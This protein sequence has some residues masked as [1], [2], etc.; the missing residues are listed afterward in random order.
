LGGAVAAFVGS[1]SVALGFTFSCFHTAW[2]SAV[3][4][5]GRGN[6]LGWSLWRKTGPSDPRRPRSA[7]EIIATVVTLQGVFTGLVGAAYVVPVL[8]KDAGLGAAL[9]PQTGRASCR[10]R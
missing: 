6:A 1:L 2:Q 4:R 9:D 7:V 5:H 8:L 3:E 10:E